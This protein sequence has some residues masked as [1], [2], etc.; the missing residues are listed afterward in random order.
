[1]QD[2]IYLSKATATEVEEA[3]VLDALR[4]GWVAP[5][6]PHV[7]AFEREI[8]ERTG[9][10]HAL[11][12]ASGT[13]ALHLALLGLG[14]KPGTAIV[15][16]SMTFSASAMPVM[17]T[18]AEPVFVDALPD[19]NVDPELFFEAID[20]VQSGGTPVV[21]AMTVDLFGRCADYDELETGLR[22]R[23]I[24]LL[25]DA[26]EALGASYHGKA[27]GSFGAMSALSFN[28]NKIMTTSGGGM[29][30]SDDADAIARARYLSTQAR[31]PV[32]HY[33]HV[34]VGYNYRLSNILAA[35]GRAQ[36]TRLDEMIARRRQIRQ[37]YADAFEDISGVSFL[38]RPEFGRD[39]A[40]DNCWLTC[41]V[42]DPDVTGVTP[43]S[44]IAELASEN[45]ESRHLW[46]PMHLQPVFASHRSFLSGV[47]ENLFNGG[48]ALPSG[49]TLRDDEV[50]RVVEV[51]RGVLGTSR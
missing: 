32:A 47:S 39:D 21:A 3:F 13:A 6:G 36:L 5:L 41:I 4:S 31:Q 40:E 26:A 35:L 2:R 27:A 22:D 25:E 46:K 38:G 23:G 50:E 20:T 1:M 18:G 33:E 7:D 49:S 43:D 9:V 48:L 17:Y 14:A 45:I 10:D 30:L 29:L 28:G 37:M 15:V 34:D 51:L 19:A 12:L 42:I 44:A 16:P 8:A 24:P 11:A